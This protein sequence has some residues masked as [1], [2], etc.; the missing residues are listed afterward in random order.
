MELTENEMNF[1]IE[2]VKMAEEEGFYILG[3]HY[4]FDAEKVGRECLAKLGIPA[5]DIEYCFRFGRWR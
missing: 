5:E 2:C 4:D 3:A 1:I